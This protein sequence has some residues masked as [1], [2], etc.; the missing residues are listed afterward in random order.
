MTELQRHRRREI[1]GTFGI[2]YAI[3]IA[4]LPV[5][6][7]KHAHPAASVLLF[8]TAF[9]LMFTLGGQVGSRARHR[10]FIVTLL[11]QTAL[12]LLIIVGATT[13]AML[14]FVALNEGW[15]LLDP[16]LLG[17]PAYLFTKP[18][19]LLGLLAAFL[20]TLFI[21]SL[22]QVGKKLGPGVLWNWI[23]GRYHDPREETR[24]FMFLDVKDSTRLA[25]QLGNLR[26]SALVRDFFSD[27]SKPVIETR[28]EVSHYIG[29]E[30]VLTWRLDRG[31]H[32][33]NCVELFFK[34]R[35]A[36]EKRREHYTKAYGMVP[37]FKAGVH[38]GP[39]VACEVGDIKSEIVFHGDVLNTAAR[40][41]S[42]CNELSSDLLVS[43]D[44]LEMLVLPGHLSS[45]YHGKF[46]FKGKEHE[47][48]VYSVGEAIREHDASSSLQEA[49]V[50][51]V[52][53]AGKDA[54]KRSPTPA[55]PPSR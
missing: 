15:S 14:P 34:M 55:S 4:S 12:Y 44:L 10:S 54:D 26:F 11:L 24:I 35:Q 36:I 27:M 16:R 47:V 28:G 42:H 41:Q 1:I 23:T 7:I 21:S 51:D 30:A 22:F 3:S 8:G 29:D 43:E 37:E 2:S 25:E 32:N 18:A 49:P 38:V 13:L 45:K 31:L 39:V 46:L 17:V 9:G 52:A 48:G 50:P 6:P 19:A 53:G 33:A 5:V 20:T 40:I